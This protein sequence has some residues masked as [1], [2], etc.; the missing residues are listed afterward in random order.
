MVEPTL[1]KLG[2]DDKQVAIY[3]ELLKSGPSPVRKI[4]FAARVNRGTT[5]DILKGLMHLGL[6]SYFHQDTHTHFTAEDPVSLAK[7]AKER[8]K[9]LERTQEEI[10]RAIPELKSLIDRD[11]G[12]PVVKFYEGSRGA[13]SIL[14]DVLE[15]VSPLMPREY[16]AYSSATIKQHL[17]R[18]YPEFSDDRIKRGIRVKVISIGEGGELRGLDQRKWLSKDEN[19]APTYFI[20]YGPKVA[21]IST[22]KDHDPL[23]VIIEN[24]AIAQTHRFLFD[25]LWDSLA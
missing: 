20:L 3:L 21:M 22:D 17:Y 10:E 8:Q 4:A 13:R 19:G 16:C 12:K 7:L 14:E 24:G 9:E 11:G 1:R 25:K 15:T 2:L 23:G 18:A 5:Y 6:V